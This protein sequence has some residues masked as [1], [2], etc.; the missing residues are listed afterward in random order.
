MENT[1]KKQKIV[2]TILSVLLGIF[3][4]LFATT[5]IITYINK[6]PYTLTMSDYYINPETQTSLCYVVDI[7]S[8]EDKI[9][10]FN[11]FAFLQKENAYQQPLRIKFNETFYYKNDS[12]IIKANEK[13]R[14]YIYTSITNIKENTIFYQ[15]KE[16]KLS[17]SIKI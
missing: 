12:F 16:L 4:I 7:T 10:K 8:P 1:I 2:I 14:L 9:I 15:K 6:K 13:N 5:N 11:D 3:I 17:K